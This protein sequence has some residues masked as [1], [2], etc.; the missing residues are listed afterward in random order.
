MESC[1]EHVRKIFFQIN[2]N[3]KIGCFGFFFWGALGFLFSQSNKYL[4][5]W[6]HNKR[7]SPSSLPQKPGNFCKGE[8]GHLK[9]ITL[10]SLCCW[11]YSNPSVPSSIMYVL[12]S[13]EDRGGEKGIC[14][15]TLLQFQSRMEHPQTESCCCVT[16]AWSWMTSRGPCWGYTSSCCELPWPLQIMEHSSTS[17][18]IL[19]VQGNWQLV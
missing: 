18:H 14:A 16:M 4:L 12:N 3:V 1:L 8:E 15:Q 7:S 9:H 13:T 17:L 5:Y 10:S 19:N 2:A 6:V 11:L